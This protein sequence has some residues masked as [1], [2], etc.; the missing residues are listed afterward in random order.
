V[1]TTQVPKVELHTDLAKVPS[2]VLPNT[3]PLIKDLLKSL[4]K[5]IL[6]KNKDFVMLVPP[7]QVLRYHMLQA[8]GPSNEGLRSPAVHI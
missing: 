5:N 6:I 7:C 8:Q 2:V 3:G 4:V 1:S